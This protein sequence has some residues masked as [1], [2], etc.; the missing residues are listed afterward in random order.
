MPRGVCEN[1]RQ[2]DVFVYSVPLAFGRTVFVC[3][4][5]LNLPQASP[6]DDEDKEG[7]SRQH[8]R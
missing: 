3:A 1:C 6:E 2:H 4:R 8:H 7:E 5:C